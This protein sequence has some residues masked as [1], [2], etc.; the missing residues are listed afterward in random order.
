MH[1]LLFFIYVNH[2]RVFAFDKTKCT[3]NRRVT[4][5]F[6]CNRESGA[7]YKL[8]AESSKQLADSADFHRLLK[9]TKNK[10]S[11]DFTD[12]H[13]LKIKLLKKY[14]LICKICGWLNHQLN[15]I[16]GSNFSISFKLKKSALIG[17]ICG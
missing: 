11:T 4:I 7:I 10:S 12:C 3:K 13:R 6:E 8:K 17:G 9:Y 1:W 16:C 14:A 15:Q 2:L 5:C